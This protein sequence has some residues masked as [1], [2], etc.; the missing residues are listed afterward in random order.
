MSETSLKPAVNPLKA[1]QKVTK[2]ALLS[3]GL[4]RI[5]QGVEVSTARLFEAIKQSP[6]VKVRLFS[7]GPFPGSTQVP[8][9]PRDFLLST[10]LKLAS[11]I[12]QRR[13]WEFAYGVEQVTYALGV[14]VPL[15]QWQPQVV[16]TK[17]APLAHVLLV[18]RDLLKLKFKI[19]FANGCGFK[20]TT[21]K[22][23]DYIQH[24]QSSSYEDAIKYGISPDKMQILSNVL[25]PLSTT[26]SRQAARASFGFRKEDWVVISVAAWDRY[27]KRI[28]YL[29][30]EVAAIQ[31]EDTRLL[32]CGHPQPDVGYLK[33]L[34]KKRLGNKVQWH[35]LPKDEIPRALAAAD[36]FVLAST[37]ELF[38]G[39]A[40]E[41]VLAELPVVMHP[42]GASRILSEHGFTATDL[43][44]PGNLATR[45]TELRKT[46]PDAKSLKKLATALKSSLSEANLTKKFVN[47]IQQ[48]AANGE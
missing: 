42:H 20:P 8:N 19:V 32:L 18:L 17:E 38:G 39:A 2:V 30:E 36:V 37:G 41:A 6:D 14:I 27:R 1:V 26:V 23:F 10:V 24:L 43:S 45:L 16:W 12:N 31:D 4:G 46:P 48:V 47:M 29:I 15:A 34:A 5:N 40:V 35:T 44:K 13:V 7:G 9:L 11:L 28:D 3:C 21:Y 25:P 22:M 33:S